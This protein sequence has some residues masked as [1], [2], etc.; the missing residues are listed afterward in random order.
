MEV[1]VILQTVVKTEKPRVKL[2]F[3]RLFFVFLSEQAQAVDR[4]VIPRRDHREHGHSAAGPSAC[5]FRQG[6]TGPLCW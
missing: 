6:C 5:S 3:L 1:T 4:G 2:M